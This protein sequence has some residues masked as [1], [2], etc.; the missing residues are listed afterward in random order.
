ML[1]YVYASAPGRQEEFKNQ[2]NL[3]NSEN[4]HENIIE[5]SRAYINFIYDIVERSRRAALREMVGL[6]RKGSSDKAIRTLILDYLQE[7]V[8]AEEIEF[9][10]KQST[11]S[12]DDW[13]LKLLQIENS[14]DAR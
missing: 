12:L 2:L 3:I 11:V 14:T 13:M 5:L 8:G 9:L 7:G 10:I 6:A 4:T 1:Q